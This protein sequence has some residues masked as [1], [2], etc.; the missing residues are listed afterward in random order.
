M[1]PA[2]L[3]LAIVHACTSPDHDSSFAFSQNPAKNAASLPHLTKGPGGLHISWVE[4]GDAIT[5]LKYATFNEAWS[6]DERVASGNNWFV[7][8]AD[9]PTIVEDA[10]GNM[11]AHFLQKSSTETF[12]YDI[13]LAT[14]KAGE[15]WSMPFGAHDDETLTEHGFVTILPNHDGTF[16]AAWLDGR[17]TGG[18]HGHGSG[19]AMTLRTARI[20]LDGSITEEKELDNRICDCCQTGGV[21]TGDG[22]LFAYRD[23]SENEIRDMAFVR[24]TPDGWIEPASVYA[25]NWEIAGCP[26]NGP[27]LASDGRTIAVAWF[28]APDQQSGV[29]V[30]FWNGE[31]FQDPIIVDESSPMGRVDIVLINETTA[32]VSWL[33]KTGDIVEIKYRIVANDGRMGSEQIVTATSEKRSSGFPQMEYLDGSLYF[34]WTDVSDSLPRILTKQILV[35]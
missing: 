26:V 31:A 30:A 20:A 1:R 12:S 3:I 6:P 19:G 17:N 11:V 23:R 15:T 25:D 34:A 13:M 8:W 9:Y 7:N 33:D 5:V 22:P 32:A 16:T 28:T 2:L 21:M 35:D 29:K 27:R 18:G 10:N 14:K 24:K 4:T